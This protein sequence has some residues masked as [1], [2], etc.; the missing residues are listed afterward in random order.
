MIELEKSSEII[1]SNKGS[2]A[3]KDQVIFAQDHTVG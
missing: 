3:L 1:Y 2:E